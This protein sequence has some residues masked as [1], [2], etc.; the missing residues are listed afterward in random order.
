M[1]KTI[2]IQIPYT[3]VN[4]EIYIK[5]EIVSAIALSQGE[6][7][8]YKVLKKSIDSRKKTILINLKIEVAINEQFSDDLF[9]LELKQVNSQSK[10]V[11]II[12]AGPAG[13]FAAIRCLQNGI[14][15]IIFEQGKNVQDRRRDLASIT[16]NRIINPNSNYCFGEGGAG[17]YS[18]GK[19][20]TRSDKRGDVNLILQL[21][22][23]F[24]ASQNIMIDTHPHIGTNKLPK[25]IENIRNTILQHGGEIYFQHALIDI[26]VND[27]KTDIKTFYIKDLVKENTQEYNCTNIILAT[28]HSA[29]G[30]FELLHKKNIAIAFKPFAMGVRVEHPQELIDTIQYH[31]STKSEL[32]DVRNVLPPAKYSLVHTTNQFSV[33]SFCMCPG[34]VIAPCA[35]DLYEVVTNGWSPSKRN[36]PYANSGIVTALSEKQV[37][38]ATKNPLAGIM[39]QQKLEQQAYRLAGSNL[40]APAQRLTD[41]INNKQSTTLPTCSYKPGISTVHLKD[42]LDNYIYLSLQKAFIDFG[43]KMKGFVSEEAVVVGVES[44][45]SSPVRIPRDKQTYKHIEINNLY[46]IGEGSGYAG[47]IVS[48]ATDG[49]NAIDKLLAN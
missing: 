42:V 49:I 25:I 6:D 37:H 48:A 20:Y 8:S 23:H 16:K 27:S 17:A 47:G 36:N 18:D 14:K 31:C 7:F 35:T 45:T 3:K 38:G 2:Q 10:I 4:D 22:I 30:I 11:Y 41:F 32:N 5:Q 34:G 29:R 39:F 9:E 13:L 15:P 43:R 33:Y 40:N 21:L 44:R 12:G 46:P 26:E 28:G 1:K 19:L 24:G